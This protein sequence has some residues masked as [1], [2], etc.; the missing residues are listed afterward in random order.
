MEEIWKDV[1]GFEGLYQ[2]SNLGRVKS[3]GYGKKERILKQK[4]IGPGYKDDKG[5]Y[6]VNLSKNNVL[7]YKSVHRLVAIAFV[8]NPDNKPEVCHKD[9]DKH[10]NCADNL[11]WGTH[12]ENCNYPLYLIRQKESQAGKQAGEKNGMYGRKR[13][14]KEKEGIRRANSKKVVCEGKVFSSV[15][16]CANYYN[17]CYSTLKTYLSKNIPKKWKELGLKYYKK[18]EL[19]EEQTN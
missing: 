5:Y 14:E 18:E 12:K 3:F 16:E 10:N 2:V 9:E 8:P 1:E 15:K 4:Q 17:V 13:T 6:G 11:I 7:Y 19:N